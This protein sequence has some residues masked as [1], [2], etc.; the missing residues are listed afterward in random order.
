MILS[1]EKRKKNKVN[2]GVRPR[3]L[4]YWV[5]ADREDLPRRARRSQGKESF[6]NS[7]LVQRIQVRLFCIPLL[8]FVPY[9]EGNNAPPI[10]FYCLIKSML[11]REAS[12]IGSLDLGFHNPQLRYPHTIAVLPSNREWSIVRSYQN[13]FLIIARSSSS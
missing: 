10:T 9:V 13:H 3:L 4:V 5:R 1:L 11:H 2:F 12:F 6:L 7:G 8:F